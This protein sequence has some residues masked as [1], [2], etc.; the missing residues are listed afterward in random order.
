MSKRWT[1]ERIIEL[2]L[3]PRHVVM[4]L[5]CRGWLLIEPDDEDED[6]GLVLAFTKGD[7]VR[8][9][10]EGWTRSRE[11]KCCSEALGGRYSLSSNGAPSDWPIGWDFEQHDPARL[12]RE[13]A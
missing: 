6:L 10:E 11:A 3:G 12:L 9:L 13:F 2:G 7:R 1:P 8:Y 4:I 5:Q